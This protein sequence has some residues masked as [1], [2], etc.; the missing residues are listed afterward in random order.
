MAAGAGGGEGFGPERCFPGAVAA[1]V[2]APAGGVVP[3]EC[4]GHAVARQVYEPVG[5]LA[6][7]A[8]HRVARCRRGV[9]GITGDAARYGGFDM[10]RMRPGPLE[11]RVV[12]LVVASPATQGAVPGEGCQDRCPPF[13]VGVAVGGAGGAAGILVSPAV[14]KNGSYS[15]GDAV[16]DPG[17][18]PDCKRQPQA[19]LGSPPVA[20]VSRA[21]QVCRGRVGW[22]TDPAHEDVG[23][24]GGTVGIAPTRFGGVGGSGSAV[25]MLDVSR[26]QAAGGVA[27]VVAAPAAV[28]SGGGPPRVVRRM[29]PGGAAAGSALGPGTGEVGHLQKADVERPVDMHAGDAIAVDRYPV[30][31]HGHGV[32]VVAGRRPVRQRPGI[33]MVA[34]PVARYCRELSRQAAMAVVA[35]DGSHVR[36]GHGAPALGRGLVD[37][38]AVGVAV[39]V[40]AGAGVGKA[41]GGPGAP[42]DIRNLVDVECIARN[43]QVA[44]VH[45]AVVTFAAAEVEAGEMQAAV[46]DMRPVAPGGYRGSRVGIAAVTPHATGKT[47]ASAPGWR[48]RHV[49]GAGQAVAVTVEIGAL[50]EAV[51]RPQVVGAAGRIT[52]VGRGRADTA[53]TAV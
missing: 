47:G 11:D 38:G 40:G 14:L 48:C 39:D 16:G 17:A 8:Y 46:V 37:P 22:V 29:A 44:A 1:D 31:G 20:V 50:A 33:D 9:A 45:R 23:A 51:A 27:G 4:S 24:G 28:E 12:S 52:P 5:V 36:F 19:K 35:A 13:A 49:L 25:V 34:V 26:R 42:I 2:A 18:A 21:V 15:W 41:A 10:F 30:L 3:A 7:V 43:R 53:V 32:A 6:P